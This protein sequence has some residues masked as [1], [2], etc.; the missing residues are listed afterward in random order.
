VVA[1]SLDSS[2]GVLRS[3]EI[4][5]PLNPTEALFL[6]TYGDPRGV[7][8]LMSEV[9]LLSYVSLVRRRLFLAAA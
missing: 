9:P 2:I 7:V 5:P 8:F 4:T 3:Y 1:F 6:G